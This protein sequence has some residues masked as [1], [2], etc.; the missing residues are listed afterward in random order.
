LF[1]PRQQGQSA[2]QAVVASRTAIDIEQNTVL[3]TS[4]IAFPGMRHL[5]QSSVTYD[6]CFAADHLLP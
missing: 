3:P 1:G 5:L 4:I 6:N 2:E